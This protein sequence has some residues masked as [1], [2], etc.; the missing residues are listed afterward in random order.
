MKKI[1][2]IKAMF[3][4]ALLIIA[5]SQSVFAEE[6]SAGRRDLAVDQL[7]ADGGMLKGALPATA[8]QMVAP[9]TG[10]TGFIDPA[11]SFPGQFPDPADFINDEQDRRGK[12]YEIKG[13]VKISRGG[14][15]WQ[16]LDNS[17][18]I[19]RG[20]IVL[21]SAE[22]YVSV[23]FDNEFKNVSHLPANTRA[24]FKNIEPL[25]LM[26]EDGTVFNIFDNLPTNSQWKVS[27]PTAVAAVR[28]THYV[29]N[30][31]AADGSLFTATFNVPDDGHQS[32]VQLID[33]LGNGQEGGSMDVPEGS[34][35]QLKEGEVPDS[36]LLSQVSEPWLSQILEILKRL[37]EFR[38]KNGFL[39]PTNGEFFAPN[40]LN[41]AG[42]TNVG[43]GLGEHQ[44]DPLDS[45]SAGF[46]QEPQ[47]QPQPEESSY[48]PEREYE[49]P[50]FEG[51]YPPFGGNEG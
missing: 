37:A 36:S 3:L 15:G 16:R 24:V 40:Y 46:P 10:Q 30:F 32:F 4:G 19:E 7:L 49:Y 13:D 41:P 51:E 9:V 2:K 1:I 25:D 29:V 26:I 44:F 23:T 45:G 47:E 28:G 21:T 35:I 17:N 5:A 22:S 31:T 50:P 39:P 27:T 11:T 14:K 42:G 8:G 6:V 18:Y 43:E 20:D 33:L 48:P 34:Q 12:V 38:R